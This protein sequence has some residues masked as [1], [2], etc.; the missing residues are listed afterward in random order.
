[1]KPQIRLASNGFSPP[2]II[3]YISKTFAVGLCGI[4][5]SNANLTWGVQHTFDDPG[6][7]GEAEI[8]VSQT[9]TTLTINDVRSKSGIV[10]HG[11][12]VNDSV[13]LRSI[14]GITDANYQVA[15]ITSQTIY[16]VTVGVSQSL[17]GVLA[18]AKNF[19]WLPHIS[20][21]AQT[22]RQDG[23]YAFPARAVRLTVS[24]YVA[25][26]IDLIVLQGSGL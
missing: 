25:G 4:P 7:E 16:T 19:R 18:Y 26:Y 5:S 22:T 13:F 23:N 14:P 9:T 11:L 21:V 20:L 6:P 15:S 17:A 12:S 24:S 8:L 3:D 2:V 1:M 10:G